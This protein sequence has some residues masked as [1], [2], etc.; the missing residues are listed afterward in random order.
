MGRSKFLKYKLKAKNAYEKT[1]NGVKIKE[2]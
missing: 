1:A 2:K